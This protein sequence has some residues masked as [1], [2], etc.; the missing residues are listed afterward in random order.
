MKV[1]IQYKQTD[2]YGVSQLVK[3]WATNPDSF[4]NFPLCVYSMTWPSCARPAFSPELAA[5]HL[6]ILTASQHSIMYF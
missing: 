6:A 5:A 1:K 2:F 4:R 3:S